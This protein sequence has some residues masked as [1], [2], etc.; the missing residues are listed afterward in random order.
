MDTPELPKEI[1]VGNT[2]YVREDS[3]PRIPYDV[4]HLLDV[5]V[6]DHLSHQEWTVMSY[7]DNID[8]GLIKKWLDSLPQETS[9]G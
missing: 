7:W 9:N 3:I 5:M 8:T 6:E 4:F 1:Y 2:C